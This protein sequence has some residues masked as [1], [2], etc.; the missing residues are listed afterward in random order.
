MISKKEIKHR[1]KTIRKYIFARN[2][3]S[4]PEFLLNKEV[5]LNL[6]I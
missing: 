4:N 5:V 1:D 6:A 3:D 2:W